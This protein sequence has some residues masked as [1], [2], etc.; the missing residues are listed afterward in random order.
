MT[1]SEVYVCDKGVVVDEGTGT[2]QDETEVRRR[3]YSGGVP[4]EELVTGIVFRFPP[5]TYIYRIS[6]NL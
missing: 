6:W 1:G 2:I 4:S 5:G 3:V